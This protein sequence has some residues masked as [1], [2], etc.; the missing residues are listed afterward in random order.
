M[1]SIQVAP[2]A[3]SG[4]AEVSESRTAALTPRELE[5]VK[6]VAA[7]ATDEEIAA[8]LFVSPRTIHSHLDNLLRK[9]GARNRTQLAVLSVLEGLEPAQNTLVR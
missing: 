5:V 2:P 4:A 6:L 8:S 1:D 3:G 7:G 9:T